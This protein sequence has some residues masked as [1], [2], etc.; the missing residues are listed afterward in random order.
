MPGLDGM[1]W[2]A[3]SP[4]SPNARRSSSS[5]PTTSTPSTPSR[6]PPTDYV[7]KPVRPERLAEAIR[8]VHVTG[9]TRP[10]RGPRRR[11][12]R[13]SRS[14]SVASPVRPAQPD[15]VRPGSRRLR[16]AAH[17]RRLPPRPNPA[18]DARGALGRRGLRPHPPQHP[19]VD[20]HVEEVRVDHGRCSV[21]VEGDRA[22]GE[23]PPR[24]PAATSCSAARRC[25]PERPAMRSP[26][27]RADH[28]ASGA[29]PAR[30]PTRRLRE[31][32]AE[33]T[34][35][36]E[37]YLHRLMRAQPRL[38][39]S[40]SP[41]APLTLGG[42]PLLFAL[43]PAPAAHV[44]RHPAAVAPP[45][46]RR[47]PH[48]RPRRPG[49]RPGERAHR[50]AVRRDH[51][52]AVSDPLAWSRPVCVPTL[53]LGI[54]GLRL[55]RHE[56][57]LRRRPRRV[58]GPQRQRD[59]RRVPLGRVLPRRRRARLRRR[60]RPALVPGRLHRRLRRPARA[61]GRSAAPRGPTPSRLRRGP[62][63]SRSGPSSV[64]VIAIGS[65]YLL[66]QVQGAGIALR[67]VRGA[68][69]WVGG[70][71]V[72]VIVAPTSPAA[73]CAR[74]R[75]SRRS[76]TGSSSRPSPS[77]PSSCSAWWRSG[78]P[79][80]SGEPAGWDEPLWGR[81]RPPPLHDVVDPAGP[82]PRHDGAAARRRPLLHQPRR[83]GRPAHDGRRARPPGL[84]LRLP[85]D[86]RLARPRPSCPGCTAA[87]DTI[88]LDLP[89]PRSGAPGRRARRGPRGR[90]VRRLPLHGGWP[91]HVGRR[92]HRPGRAAAPAGTADEGDSSCGNSSACPPSS[93]SS[94][95]TSSARPHRAP[96]ARD[97]RGPRLRRRGGDLAPLLILGVWWARLR[98]RRRRGV[99]PRWRRR[100]HRGH[101]DDLRRG[102]A[103][104]GSARS[105]STPPCGP[106]R[107]PSAAPSSSRCSPPA[108]CRH[109]PRRPSC[110]STRPS[111]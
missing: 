7:M 13:R 93:R 6:S 79:A 15:P 47:L 44:V 62:L 89:V 43:F 8:R 46:C 97:D 42:L 26:P 98:A 111:R 69:T 52:G 87:S 33:Q 80:P 51:R 101:R 109:A 36:G 66:P 64:L 63:E 60:R 30:R 54:F 71:L 34:G 76:S 110:G 100:D 88:V 70:L 67:Q 17:R 24:P 22:A 84:L 73:G 10:R 57:L 68:P 23:P 20:G 58:T 85:A 107:S 104:A 106:R 56:R 96:R 12:T 29:S 75:W 16:P 11:R 59:R 83:P 102:P 72:A 74:S 77:P 21:V 103:R 90:G 82:Q 40:S 99:G 38:A 95:P 81:Q 18:D 55:S 78:A 3:W 2:P 92:G 19:G 1:G 32:V 49:L 25:E 31:E 105:S 9:L 61:R 37:V 28:R 108:R 4:A 65:L 35:L 39:L 27:P 14:S 86:L 5:P 53:A 48:L 94:G 41:S 50:G 45:G 91:R